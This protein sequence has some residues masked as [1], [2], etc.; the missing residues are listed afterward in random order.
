M[1]VTALPLSLLGLLTLGVAP[2]Q[3]PQVQ[4]WEKTIAPGLVYR[5]ELDP[6]VPRT[7]HALRFS[8]QSPSLRWSTELG[9]GTINEEGT[10]KGRA[11]PA[12]MAAKTGAIAVINGDFFSFEHGAPI[13]EMVRNGEL[14]TTAARPRDVF[15]WGPKEARLGLADASASATPDGGRE[16]PLESVNQPVGASGVALYTPVVGIAEVRKPNITAVLKIPDAP[17]SP[18]GTVTATFDYALPD[19]T[20]TPVPAGRALL[21]ATGDAIPR[22]ASFRPGQR[23]TLRVKTNGFDWERFENVIGGGNALVRGGEI[24][25]D[26]KAMGFGKEFIDERHPRSAVGRTASGDILIVAVDGRQTCS[27]GATLVEMA[28]IMKRLG[29]IEAMN[30]DGGGS[31]ALNLLGMTIN[32]PSSGAERPVVNG[33]ALYG[34]KPPAATGT[35]RIVVP[36]RIENG[37]MAQAT[38]EMDGKPVPNADILWTSRGTVWID[39][40]GTLH[41]TFA[42]PAKVMAHVYGQ[43]I[44]AKL[45]VTGAPP[46]DPK[47]VPLADGGK[48][49]ED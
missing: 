13:G 5:M 32:R 12:D 45:T 34:P 43:T 33:I 23:I 49:V 31:T 2:R 39:Q 37:T 21:V 36:A 46:A 15:A 9:G 4:S 1:R 16:I 3:T 47:K 44:Q 29:C 10:V 30:L 17:I 35:P 48:G 11:T 40:G 42:G 27:L 38:V 24:A 18:S 41:S 25:V 28:G 26:A 19:A 6:G 22:I 20:R 7:I 14:I 8:P